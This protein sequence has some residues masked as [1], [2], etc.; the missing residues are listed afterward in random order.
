MLIPRFNQFMESVDNVVYLIG[1]YVGFPR[2]FAEVENLIN[3]PN[4]VG[5]RPEMAKE[6]SPLPAA[7]HG[8]ATAV[9]NDKI[10][11]FGGFENGSL[12]SK[13]FEYDPA[14][15]MWNPKSVIPYGAVQGASAVTAGPG[16]IVFGGA[17][18]FGNAKTAAYSYQPSLDQ[19]APLSDMPSAH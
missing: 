15:D 9:F 6:R 13:V 12:T 10:Y 7:Q 17:D 19:W 1:G 11:S 5:Y 2:W 14:T 3:F 8:G 18:E 4:V 16:I